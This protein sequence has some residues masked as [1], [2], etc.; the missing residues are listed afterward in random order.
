MSFEEVVF[1]IIIYSGNSKAYCFQALSLAREGNFKECDALMEKSKAE[2]LEAHH[3]QTRLI[4]D[5][6][7]GKKHELSLLMV[8]AQDHMMNASLAKDLIAEMIL[9]YKERF[10]NK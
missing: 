1:N 2:L 8:H 3:I 7:A 10:N 5:E 6:A 4:Q 9:M